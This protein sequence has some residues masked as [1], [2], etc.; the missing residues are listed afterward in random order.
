MVG[1]STQKMECARR[2]LFGEQVDLE[3]DVVAPFR[4]TVHGI[5]PDQHAGGEQYGLDRQEGRQQRIGERVNSPGVPRIN[6]VKRDP[7]GDQHALANDKMDCAEERADRV[8]HAVQEGEFLP[9]LLFDLQDGFDTVGCRLPGGWRRIYN[10]G[11]G[12]LVTTRM[13][14]ACPRDMKFETLDA[15]QEFETFDASQSLARSLAITPPQGSHACNGGEPRRF[16]VRD[17]RAP[18]VPGYGIVIMDATC[19]TRRKTLPTL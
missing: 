18:R 17:P 8:K 14:S 13:A 5:L 11:H 15:S 10:R 6:L 4:G 7:N 1:N 12:H 9:V 19:P 16:P 3:F 2:F